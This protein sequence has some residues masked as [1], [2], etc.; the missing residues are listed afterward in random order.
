MEKASL[1][2]IRWLLEIIKAK[3]NNELLL[4][5][6]KNL[7]ELG[8]S[9]V[10]PRENSNFLKKGKIIISIKIRNFSRS[11]VTK[12]NFPLNSSREI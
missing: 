3:H 10:K 4:L 9:P 7:Q 6:M 5:S 11:R 2:R 12:W 1:E 8:V